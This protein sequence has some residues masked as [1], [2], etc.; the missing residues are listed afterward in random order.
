MLNGEFAVDQLK[1]L[2]LFKRRQSFIHSVDGSL[3]FLVNRFGFVQ[4]HTFRL[5]TGNGLGNR[6]GEREERYQMRQAVTGEQNLVDD[7]L[8]LEQALHVRCSPAM[9]SAFGV[10]RPFFRYSSRR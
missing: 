1:A 2:D 8:T 6:G 3:Y 4:G 7:R 10:T 9:V 5:G